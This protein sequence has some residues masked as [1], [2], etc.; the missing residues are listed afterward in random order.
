[1][2]PETN[3][4]VNSLIRP[5]PFAD[6][7][8]AWCLGYLHAQK[9]PTRAQV[10]C[11]IAYRSSFVSIHHPVDYSCMYAYTM[12]TSKVQTKLLSDADLQKRQAKDLSDH[13]TLLSALQGLSNNVGYTLL[14]VIQTDTVDVQTHI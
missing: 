1:M 12:H 8:V 9:A 2:G 7:P 13:C 3:Q 14:P 10:I 4:A 6:Y 11:N 5:P